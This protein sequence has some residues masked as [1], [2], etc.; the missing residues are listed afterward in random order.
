M[1]DGADQEAREALARCYAVL[2]TLDARERAAYTLR[3]LEEMTMEEVARHLATSLSTAKRL[4]NR[5][6]TLV[7][8]AVGKDK[9][10]FS[11][12]TDGDKLGGQ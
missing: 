9:D 8:A 5:S 3:Y 11:Y 2:N 12:F 1:V 10:L 6:T 4:V 7:A